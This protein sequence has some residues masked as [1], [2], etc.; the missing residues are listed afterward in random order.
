MVHL[1]YDTWI[2]YKPLPFL[3][4]NNSTVPLQK[5]LRSDEGFNAEDTSCKILSIN[6]LNIDEVSLYNEVNTGGFI[7]THVI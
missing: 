4:D 7:T 5:S 1:D 3:E 2:H 6:F